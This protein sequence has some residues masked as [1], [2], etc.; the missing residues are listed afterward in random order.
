MDDSIFFGFASLFSILS[1][2]SCTPLPGMHYALNR[3]HL[4]F[5]PG[6]GTPL[7]WKNMGTAIRLLA[8]WVGEVKS[9]LMIESG[10]LKH[11]WLEMAKLTIRKIETFSLD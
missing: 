10:H 4:R 3:E 5:N 6:F 2:T 1:Y 11:L 8:Y 9:R 7:T